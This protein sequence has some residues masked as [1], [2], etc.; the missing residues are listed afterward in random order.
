MVQAK[1]QQQ[2]QQEQRS[3]LA[4]GENVYVSVDRSLD[5]ME[6][7]ALFTRTTQ[8]PPQTKKAKNK[9]RKKRAAKRLKQQQQPLEQQKAK[10]SVDNYESLNDLNTQE[11][12]VSLHRQPRPRP[13]PPPPRPSSTSSSNAS[14]RRQPPA[15]TQSSHTALFMDAWLHQRWLYSSLHGCLVTPLTLLTSLLTLAISAWLQVDARVLFLVN[16]SNRLDYAA[17]SRLVGLAPRLLLATGLL[18]LL[19]DIGSL[20]LHARLIAPFLADHSRSPKRIA[21]I[22]HNQ[23]SIAKV[24]S[25]SVNNNN[26]NTSSNKF[27]AYARLLSERMRLRGFAGLVK[28]RR[29]ALAV[30]AML[31]ACSLL[32]VCAVQLSVAVMAL[33]FVDRLVG[34]QLPQTLVRLVRAYEAKQLAQLATLDLLLLRRRQYAP[35]NSLEEHLVGK[36]HTL[37]ACCHYSNPYQY[38]LMVPP[39]CTHFDTGCLRPAQDFTWHVVFVGGACVLV[40]ATLRLC[41]LFVSGLAFRTVFVRRLVDALYELDVSAYRKRFVNADNFDTFC[42]TT[43]TDEH[44]DTTL[45]ATAAASAGE[46][47]EDGG[48]DDDDNNAAAQMQRL[49][50]IRRRKELALEQEEREEDER[51]EREQMQ[52]SRLV[53]L[54]AIQQRYEEM[55]IR[56]KR[57]DEL[58]FQREQRHLQMQHLLDPP[59]H[60]DDDDHD[61]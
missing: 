42:D 37:F 15:P 23:I 47:S 6:S 51:R 43:D 40:L 33:V 13:P 36:M 39:T 54:D 32:L 52:L 25:I 57:F 48:D 16:L 44:N 30:F 20:F 34:Y 61:Y 11:E 2:K 35:T 12:P 7:A 58:R 55:L 10:G 3:V 27:K 49:A 8:P 1:Q 17:M 50:D 56:Q 21:R 31:G 24:L 41:M 14:P 46:L 9:T 4:N 45:A 53:E 28:M 18:A 59:H 26:N 5:N 22:V 19:L 60:S 38:G 29:H